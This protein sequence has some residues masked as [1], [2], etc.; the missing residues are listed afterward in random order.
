MQG[1]VFIQ[2]Q[3]YDTL[4]IF[5]TWLRKAD[6]IKS[7]VA[8]EGDVASGPLVVTMLDVYR[9]FKSKTGLV[10]YIIFYAKDKIQYLQ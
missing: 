2:N 1:N 3:S 8:Q 10:L 5:C 7:L 6:S 9:V 4:Q